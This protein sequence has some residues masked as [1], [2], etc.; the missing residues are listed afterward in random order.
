MFKN[1]RLV[2]ALA[3]AVATAPIAAAEDFQ[4]SAGGEYLFDS[5]DSEF[6]FT[7]ITGRGA[8]YFNKNVGIEGEATFGTSG[9]DNYGGSGINFDLENQ[10]GGYLVGRMPAGQSGELFGRVGF[11]AGTLSVTSD[12]GWFYIDEEIDYNGFSIGGGYTHFFNKS[13]GLR[14]EVTTSGASLD[15]NFS[16]DGNLT[17]FS[18]SL[19]YK[20]GGKE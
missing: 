5:A 6:A 18:L 2:A 17:S 8:Y 19:V 20:F 4:F 13:L 12:S 9:A 1:I 11:R 16:P 3:A 14:G 10:F 15:N 7:G